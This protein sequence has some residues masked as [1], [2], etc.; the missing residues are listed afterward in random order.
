MPL[1]SG[2]FPTGSFAANHHRQMV[3]RPETR[4]FAPPDFRF[5]D[6][7]GQCGPTPEEG[8]QRASAFNPRKLMAKAEMDSGAEGNVPVWPALQISRS[9]A[10]LRVSCWR[11]HDN[12]PVALS[13]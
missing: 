13:V 3:D 4:P 8:F 6:R 1:P 10:G 11:P 5:I 7:E 2:R 9:N 12:D